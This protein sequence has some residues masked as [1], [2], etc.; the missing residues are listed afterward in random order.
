MASPPSVCD[1]E[2]QKKKRLDG[3]YTAMDSAVGTSG[4]EKAR[5]DYY[6]VK[7][8][9]GWLQTEKER[10]AKRDVE[11]ILNKYNAQYDQL[12]QQIDQQKQISDYATQIKTQ[13]SGAQEDVNFLD[14]QLQLE[15]DKVGV[16]QRLTQL[17]QTISTTP[18]WLP[19]VLDV[20]IGI[21]A[22]Y[23]IYMI[24]FGGK[25]MSVYNRFVPATSSP[26]VL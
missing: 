17:M 20:I 21:L 8:G 15:K 4:Y 7:E 6:T 25:I 16:A 2:C 1:A 24:S 10:I 13:Q 11:P 23:I 12:T 26:S 22:V 18:S 19:V 14:K 5:I 9:Q 3:L